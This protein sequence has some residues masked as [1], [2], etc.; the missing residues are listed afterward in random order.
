MEA[1]CPLQ[2][3]AD[4]FKRLARDLQSWSQHKTGHIRRQ[5]QSAR[6]IV[7]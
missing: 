1:T 5:L 6:E 2:H 7:H 3:L 4:K